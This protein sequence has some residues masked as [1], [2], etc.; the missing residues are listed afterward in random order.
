MNM[1][2]IA[3]LLQVLALAWQL[4]SPAHAMSAADRGKLRVALFDSGYN[5]DPSLLC[6]EGHFDAPRNRRFTKAEYL[7][8]K[9]LGRDQIGHG[10]LVARII[11]D[12]IRKETAYCFLI[13]KVFAGRD[14]TFINGTPYLHLL[15]VKP[16]VV[17]MSISGPYQFV[18]NVMERYVIE[19]LR[20]TTAFIV[21]AGNEETNLDVNCNI[22][23]ACYRLPNVTTVGG[24]D[25]TGHRAMGSNWATWIK[26]WAPYCVSENNCGTS[27][28]APAITAEYV[29]EYYRRKMPPPPPPPSYT[30][31]SRE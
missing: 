30:G 27:F 19:E 24:L 21:A 26:S 9:G 8:T 6:E 29:N 12:G 2:P 28:S 18:I 1:R 17:N 11:Q 23:P 3:P 10:T 31:K 5:G 25:S 22:Y 20:N 4:S 13:I 14:H 16:D 15:A 7:T